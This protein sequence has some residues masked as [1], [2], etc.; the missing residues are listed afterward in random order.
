MW[1][2]LRTGQIGFPGGLTKNDVM[3]GSLIHLVAAAAVLEQALVDP[4]EKVACAQTQLC[5][6]AHGAIDLAHAIAVGCNRYFARASRLLNA[7]LFLRY[8]AD[9]GLNRELGKFASGEFPSN[10]TGSAGQ[11]LIGIDPSFRPT[12]VQLLRLSALIAANG[13]LPML[14]S[15][16][17]DV[18]GPEPISPQL[19]ETTW[20]FLRDA[21]H[22]SCLTGMAIDLDPKLALDISAC[23]NTLPFGAK[24]ASTMVGFF[25]YEK[26][27]YAF[28]AAQALVGED[29]NAILFAQKYLFAQPWP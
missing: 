20:Q 15:A 4:Y 3:P 21:M 11:L 26:P 22:L 23:L 2:D 16:E 18:S 10:R 27:V 17:E 13:K 5:S 8:C 19:K 12:A 24:Y 29:E 6:T 9:F 14:H 7:E 28:Y 25:P 1:A